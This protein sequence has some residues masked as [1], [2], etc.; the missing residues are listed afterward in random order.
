M[1]QPSIT[2]IDYGIGNTHSVMHAI[3]YLGYRKI[4]I[5]DQSNHIAISEVC[6]LNTSDAAK[7][8]EVENPG[9]PIPFKI[10]RLL[11]FTIYIVFVFF[12]V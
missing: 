8:R 2:I 7:K 4:R 11:Y 10:K 6:L 1:K 12:D 5:S 3:P 9:V